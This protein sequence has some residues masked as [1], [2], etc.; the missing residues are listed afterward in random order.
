MKKWL[1]RFSWLFMALLAVA[2]LV[3]VTRSNPPVEA[4][5][6][7]PA[8]VRTILRRA[9]YDYHSNEVVWPW[10]AR[11]AP[12]SWLVARDVNEGREAINY[13][14]WNRYDT[15]TRGELAWETWE[16]VSEGEMPPWFYVAAHP[17]SR[18][19][20]DDRA[21]LRT[22]AMAFDGGHRTEDDH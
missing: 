4:V 21:T 8:R 14:T 16:E 20:D 11:V 13:S 3:P 12:A 5:V 6:P 9:C 10:Y 2:Q 18:L 19:T 17:E 1:R 7:A 22:W 15:E